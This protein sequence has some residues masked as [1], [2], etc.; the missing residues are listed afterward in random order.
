MEMG[1]SVDEFKYSRSIEGKDSPNFEML[2]ARTASA[3]NKI[4]QN[5]H[6]KKKVN[7][8]EQKAQ[9]EDRFLRGRQ[10]AYMIYDNFRVTG[11]H[12]TA[13]D[14]ADLFSITLRNDDVQDFDTILDEILLSV[15]KVPSDDVLESLC[16]LRIRES[17][18][19]KTTLELY[20]MEIHQEISIPNY[21]KSKT[22]VTRSIDQ[23][24]RILNFDARNKKI[25]TGAV[26]TSRRGLSGVERG[27]EICYQWVREETNAVSSTRV[28]SVQ[29]RH[30][31]PLHPLSHQQEVEVRREK[32]PQKQE[33]V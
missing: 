13:L 20:D 28:M 9:Q 22:N 10:I 8:E 21:E 31:K 27:K 19:L 14:Y 6:F 24:L 11:T 4:I 29:N 25:E 17:D 15:T 30:R 23:K 3:L 18:Q 16:K 7:L 12:D 33:S 32:E 2:D 1:D 26:V 5:S